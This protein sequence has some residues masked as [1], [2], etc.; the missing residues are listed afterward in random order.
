MNRLQTYFRSAGDAP[1]HYVYRF[2]RMRALLR[3]RFINSTKNR[4]INAVVL[5]EW[6]RRFPSKQEIAR[7]SPTMYHTLV[8]LQRPLAV[9]LVNSIQ[10]GI[11]RLKI[12]DLFH[13]SPCKIQTKQEF[14]NWLKNGCITLFKSLD[15]AVISIQ[16]HLSIL[17]KSTFL[18][19]YLDLSSRT[20]FF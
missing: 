13:P 14:L 7:S 15:W 19:P 9:K 11:V 18:W 5:A 6:L 17:I 8:H 16:L 12:T 20:R 10:W 1:R 2:L 3:S 4:K